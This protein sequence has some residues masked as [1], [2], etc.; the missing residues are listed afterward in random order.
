[1]SSTIMVGNSSGWNAVGTRVAH[2]NTGHGSDM[3]G[4]STPSG[5]VGL[6]VGEY[7][8]AGSVQEKRTINAGLNVSGWIAHT[9][10]DCRVHVKTGAIL[11]ITRK[12]EDEDGK[13]VRARYTRT[14]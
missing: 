6:E 9:L 12:F 1:M 10:A 8:D 14:S 11:E 3:V 4:I 7:L 2:A 5:I 13:W